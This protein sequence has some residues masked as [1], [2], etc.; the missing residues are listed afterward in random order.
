METNLYLVEI[1]STDH[2]TVNTVPY[3]SLEEAAKR[4]T[5]AVMLNA[6]PFASIRV[7]YW[8]DDKKGYDYIK[9]ITIIG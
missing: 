8:A 3:K 6:T 4:A 2:I 9:E 5:A 7:F 1:K